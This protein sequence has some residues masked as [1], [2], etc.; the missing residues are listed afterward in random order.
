MKMTISARIMS[1][2]AIGA[3][4][5][6]FAGAMDITQLLRTRDQLVGISTTLVPSTI[7]LY[8]AAESFQSLQAR[9][10]RAVLSG[11]ADNIQT[12]EKEIAA[13]REELE[14]RLKNYEAFDLDTH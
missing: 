10:L 1:L 12:T 11:N 8:G 6:M 13:E 5:L 7:D 4:A 14:G 3:A 9:A 2:V